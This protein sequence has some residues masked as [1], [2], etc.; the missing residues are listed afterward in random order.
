MLESHTNSLAGRERGGKEVAV[1]C[2][3]DKFIGYRDCNCFWSGRKQLG[4]RGTQALR[5]VGQYP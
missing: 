2:L 3:T 5:K 1:Y 4:S